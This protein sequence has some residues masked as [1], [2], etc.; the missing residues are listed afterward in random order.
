MTIEFSLRR[1]ATQARCLGIL[2]LSLTT[3]ILLT[4]F[5]SLPTMVART[6][7]SVNSLNIPNSEAAAIPKSDGADGRSTFTSVQLFAMVTV[8]LGLCAVS[9][10]CFF[11]GRVACM[12]IELAARFNALA[13]ALCLAGDDFGQ[14]ERAALIV[15]PKSKY[16]SAPDLFSLKDIKAVADVVKPL[17]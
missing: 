13:D 12:E 17:R 14:L 10:A 8:V 15:V 2:W 16:P 4:A 6:A 7:T 3:L 1:R 9:L 5:V 11:L